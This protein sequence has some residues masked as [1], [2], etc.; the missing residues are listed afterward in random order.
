MQRINAGE[1]V[2]LL[3]DESKLEWNKTGLIG[4]ADKTIN[5]DIVSDAFKMPKP[6]NAKPVNDG[7]VLPG[8]DYAIVT[9]YEVHDGDPS[10]VDAAEREKLKASTL[11]NNGQ[12]LGNIVSDE[13]RQKAK[14]TEFPDRL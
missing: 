11:R 3:A 9:V 2:E 7:F 4:R 5:T 1:N 8:G 10:A 12:L 6:E 13:L 14:I